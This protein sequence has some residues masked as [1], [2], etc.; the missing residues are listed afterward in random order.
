MLIIIKKQTYFSNYI[1][2][3]VYFKYIKSKSLRY[4]VLTLLCNGLDQIQIKTDFTKY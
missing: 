4:Y 1:G 2:I 3:T